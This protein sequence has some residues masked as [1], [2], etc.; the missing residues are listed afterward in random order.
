MTS[1]KALRATFVVDSVETLSCI[2][3]N[4]ESRSQEL[5]NITIRQAAGGRAAVEGSAQDVLFFLGEYAGAG[6]D[7]VFD[8]LPV[9][10]IVRSV[11]HSYE[12][13]LAASW[14]SAPSATYTVYAA[15]RAQART[16]AE[17][18]GYTVYSVNFAG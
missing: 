7:D 13:E 6:F 18:A 12:L 15:N 10:P 5:L 1:N 17:R 16:K 8:V 3:H 11:L 2:R 9:S 4:H 14:I